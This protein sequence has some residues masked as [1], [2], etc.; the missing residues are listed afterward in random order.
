MN[1]GESI[2]FLVFMSIPYP[3][4]FFVFGIS[5]ISLSSRRLHDTGR[6]G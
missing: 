4:T 3:I 6:S 5:M 1:G 2:M